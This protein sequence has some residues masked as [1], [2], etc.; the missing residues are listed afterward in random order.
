MP[1][2]RGLSLTVLRRKKAEVNWCGT[3]LAVRSNITKNEELLSYEYSSKTYWKVII[4]NSTLLKSSKVSCYMPSNVLSLTF[5]LRKTFFFSK[6]FLGDPPPLIFLEVCLKFRSM[7]RWS[8]KFDF[9]IAR[10]PKKH[11]SSDVELRSIV[12]NFVT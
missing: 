2:G 1:L 12:P 11:Y 10:S 6:I 4:S 8:E 9:H 3:A 7:E 5:F